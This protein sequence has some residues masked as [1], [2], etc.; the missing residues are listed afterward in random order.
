[1]IQTR[2]PHRRPKLYAV[3]TGRAAAA[4]WL[5]LAGAILAWP[6][7]ESL[8]HR[9]WRGFGDQMRR[10]RNRPPPNPGRGEGA[11][12]P[13]DIPLP[14]W[15]DIALR[16]WSDFNADRITQVAGGVAFFALLSIFPALAAFVS[17]YGLFGDVGAAEKELSFLS[18][19]L[20]HDT[21]KFAAEQMARFAAKGAG[22]LTFAF[23]VSLLISVWSANGA[24]K[25]LFDGLNVAYEQREKRGLIT[26]N[27]LS[28]TFT[29]GG[30]AFMIAALSAV[31]AT[32]SILAAL[33]YR[34]S[35]A[36]LNIARWPAMLAAAITALSILYRYGPSRRRARWRWITWGGA[37]AALLWLLA[38]MAF[39]WYV[40]AFAHYDRT[41]GSLGAVV[42]FMTW[43][44]LS[45]TIILAG[46]ELNSEVEAQT[47]A[48]T[49]IDGRTT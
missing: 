47:G 49:S 9:F 31:I 32:P 40:S 21:I 6:R 39:S 28:L 33:G 10:W 27:A 2:A 3:W 24:V 20:P 16:T 23:A 19:V 14:G 11:A 8:S 34:E 36:G 43:I 35:L 42:A 48:D 46:A 18:G 22:Q 17:L 30:L 44:W 26:L 1:M 25:A 12:S 15:K 7:E 41:Y 4:G 13:A 38:S 5:I 45:T 37:A 29:V